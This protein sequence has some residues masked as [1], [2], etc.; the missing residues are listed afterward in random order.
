MQLF[1]LMFSRFI[2]EFTTFSVVCFT[3]ILNNSAA[4]AVLFV[5]QNMLFI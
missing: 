4:N 1:I 3:D 5:L 2:Y